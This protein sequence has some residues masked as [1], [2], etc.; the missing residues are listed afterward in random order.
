MW[1][2]NNWS[3]LDRKLRGQNYSK[4]NYFFFYIMKPNIWL[5]RPNYKKPLECIHTF[6]INHFFFFSKKYRSPPHAYTN[7]NWHISRHSFMLP[8]LPHQP[9]NV[10]GLGFPL[11]ERDVREKRFDPF[12]FSHFRAICAYTKNDDRDFL[13]SVCACLLCVCVG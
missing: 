12:L 9:F 8:K 10:L 3:P 5:L 1:R 11:F 2:K 7:S 6:C 13:W 4:Q